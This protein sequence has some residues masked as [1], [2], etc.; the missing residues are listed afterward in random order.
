MKIARKLNEHTLKHPNWIFKKLVGIL[1]KFKED[2]VLLSIH[3][4]MIIC[5]EHAQHGDYSIL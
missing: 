5:Q 1:K 4:F 2:Y 3:I